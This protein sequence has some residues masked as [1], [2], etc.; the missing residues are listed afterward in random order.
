MSKSKLVGKI[1]LD[2]VLLKFKENNKNFKNDLER[3]ENSER[4]ETIESI[5]NDIKG[6][7]MNTE[8]KKNKFINDIKLSLGEEVKKNPNG[9][10]IIKKKWYQRLGSIIKN[11]FTRF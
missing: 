9:I 2:E 10:E 6:D 4:V 11:I 3:S 8:L 7:I 5:Q 1:S